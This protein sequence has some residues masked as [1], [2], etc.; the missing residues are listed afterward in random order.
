[1]FNIKEINKTNLI[2]NIKQVKLKNPNSLICAMVKA[3]AYGVGIKQVAKILSPYADFFGVA[4][5]FEACQVRKSCINK[6][7]IVGPLERNKIDNSFSY[8][9]GNLNDVN[10]LLSLKI[11]L[12]IHLK[13]NTGMNRYGFN[14]LT[15]FK[16]AL[17]KIENSLLYLEGVFTHFATT[18][19]FVEKQMKL[20]KKYINACLS[21]GFNPLFHADNSF[22]N[23]AKNHN[24]DMVRIGFNLF[25]GTG[26]FSS[27]LKIKSKIVKINKIKAGDIVGY[28]YKF[29]APKAMDVAVVP[30][31]YADGFDTHFIGI[32]LNINGKECKVLNVCMDCF[33]LDISKTNLKLNDEIEIL[34]ETNTAKK[35]AQFINS[36]E[37]EVLTKFNFF[38]GKTIIKE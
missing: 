28:N 23:E 16:K 20:F 5:F 35:Y 9:C 17:K 36:S 2:N 11:P 15:E 8:T 22:V 24:L 1:M 34:N 13:V 21:M 25:N 38:R 27:V 3:N 26:K 6:I 12:K 19:Q 30:I 7:L 33:M 4:C 10:F 14:S 32:N 29:V 31:G 37:Y 18:D